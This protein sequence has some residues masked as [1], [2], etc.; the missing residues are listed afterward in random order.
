MPEVEAEA[1]AEVKAEA[2]VSPTN[3]SGSEMERTTALCGSTA[4]FAS[5][6]NTES[7]AFSIRAD[8]RTE[9]RGSVQCGGGGGGREERCGEWV[10][11]TPEATVRKAAD[12]LG[13]AL[14]WR[15]GASSVSVSDI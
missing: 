13:L 10:C 4:S 14:V 3:G 9:V 1:A 7:C 12:C 11:P 2:E 6:G 5:S 8:G 15:A